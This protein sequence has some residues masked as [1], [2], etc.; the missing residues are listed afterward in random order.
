[1]NHLP[2]RMDSGIGAAGTRHGNRMICYFGQCRF[3]TDLDRASLRLA[4]PPKKTAAVVFDTKCNAHDAE[5]TL[6]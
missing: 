4:L 5:L 3:D 2:G 6:R 1:M